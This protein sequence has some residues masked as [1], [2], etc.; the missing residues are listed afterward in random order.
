[1]RVTGLDGKDYPWKLTGKMVN[2]GDLRPRSSYHLK[3]RKLLQTMFTASPIL[4]EVELP[5]TGGLRADF[6]LPQ[7]RRVVEVHGEQHYKFSL[8]FHGDKKGFL[9]AKKRDSDKSEWCAINN[10]KYVALAFSE[11]ED[12][13]R[14]LI[15]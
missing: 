11:S 14:R 15:G 12:E 9:M 4:E 13:W 8:H 6:Y 3:A 7:Q 1:M 2:S 5:G 10:I